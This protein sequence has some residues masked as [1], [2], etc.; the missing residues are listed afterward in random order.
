MALLSRD[1]PHSNL[2][3]RIIGVAM[4]VHGRLG[5][6][7]PESVYQKALELKLPEAGLSF[8]AQKPLEVLLDGTGL[9]LYYLDFLIEEQIILEIKSKSGRM[10][11]VDQWLTPP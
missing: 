10:S 1:A 3:F 5:P 4:E 6:G 9:A 7:H 2:T 8:E 11:P